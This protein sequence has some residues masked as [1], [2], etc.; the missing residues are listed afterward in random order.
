[1]EDVIFA[2]SGARQPVGVAEVTLTIDNSDHFIPIDFTELNIDVK[3]KG[4]IIDLYA[5]DLFLARID[6]T[7]VN[8]CARALLCVS[9]CDPA[10]ELRA[11]A[12]CNIHGVWMGTVS[13]TVM[14]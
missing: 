1:M 13:I 10:K 4:A 9:L 11:Y 3:A 12:R 7:A 6:L 5:D 2:G 8:T 14:E